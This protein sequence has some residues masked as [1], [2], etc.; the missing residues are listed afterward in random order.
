MFPMHFMYSLRL[1][2]YAPLPWLQWTQIEWYLIY[3]CNLGLK[4]C[5]VLKWL[6]D[7]MSYSAAMLHFLV[8][9]CKI[10]IFLSSH[11]IV[12]SNSVSLKRL[13]RELKLKFTIIDALQ[14]KPSLK[15]PSNHLLFIT[16]WMGSWNIQISHS[17][18]RCSHLEL[19]LSA[20][21]KIN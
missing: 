1:I 8:I 20:K 18:L 11:I 12:I 17:T 10:L 7:Q 15:P 19:L 9:I 5:F 21:Q 13:Y 4:K 14:L 16:N 2:C 6:C 3:L